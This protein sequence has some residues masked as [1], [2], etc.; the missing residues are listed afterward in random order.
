MTGLSAI[1][2]QMYPMY[3]QI[4]KAI[5]ETF[6]PGDQFSFYFMCTCHMKYSVMDHYFS[7]R[8]TTSSVC[9]NRHFCLC[10]MKIT[11]ETFLQCKYYKDEAGIGRGIHQGPV[12]YRLVSFPEP[13]H[14]A[15]VIFVFIPPLLLQCG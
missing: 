1:R 4:E 7:T 12:N 9:S 8:D 3:L 11:N 2:S 6:T 15:V 10:F 14:K 5:T 13:E